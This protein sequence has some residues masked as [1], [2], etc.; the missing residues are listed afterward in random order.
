MDK[1]YVKNLSPKLS[2]VQVKKSLKYE[3]R[4]SRFLNFSY[5]ALFATAVVCLNGVRKDYIL[6]RNDSIEVVMFKEA[7]ARLK[8]AV[9]YFNHNGNSIPL[10]SRYAAL[11]D[12]ARLEIEKTRLY[13]SK[14][15]QEYDSKMR[16][17]NKDA[18]YESYGGLMIAAILAGLSGFYNHK[19]KM[20]NAKV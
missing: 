8:S 2:Y 11:E 5:V 20:L 6:D 12:I 19:N 3:R 13:N 15:Y 10:P 4:R 9:K 18:M 14:T 16:K 1:D 7:D 17:L